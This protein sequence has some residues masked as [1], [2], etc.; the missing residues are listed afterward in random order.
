MMIR[1][2]RELCVHFHGEAIASLTKSAGSIQ[3]SHT[4]KPRCVGHP[5]LKPDF[6]SSEMEN[7]SIDVTS[8]APMA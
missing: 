1:V 3:I 5:P 2:N 4:T 6:G 8:V 7:K